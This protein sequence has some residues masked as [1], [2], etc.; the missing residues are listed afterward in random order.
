MASQVWIFEKPSKKDGVVFIGLPGI[1][2]VGKIVV[3]YLI[4]ELKPKKIADITSDSF[5]SAVITKK[6]ILSLVKDEIYFLEHHGKPF[7]LVAGPAF[8]N[9]D[10]ETGGTEAH[11]DF[12]RTLITAFQQL[13]VKE[14]VTLAGLNIG[15][16]RITTEPSVV[17]AATDKKTLELWKTKGAKQGPKE[18]LIMGHAGMILGVGKT[19]GIPGACLMGETSSKLVYGDPGASKTVLDVL[20]KRFGFKIKMNKIVAEAKEIEKAFTKLAET[21]QAEEKETAIRDLPYVR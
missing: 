10:P 1:G 4:K 11:Y 18:G 5:P 19:Q 12:A 2:L 20:V 13:N 8:L 16:E 6:G 14:I 7:Y 17:L 21:I 9:Y 15:E 3:D